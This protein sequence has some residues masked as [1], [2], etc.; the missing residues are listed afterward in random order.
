MMRPLLF[1]LNRSFADPKA[2]SGMFF[3]PHSA[4]VEGLLS[5]HPELRE[6]LDV[7]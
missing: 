5:S 6:R 7:R 1:I 3:C 2:G 4:T